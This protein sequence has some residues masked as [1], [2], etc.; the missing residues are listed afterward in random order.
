[1]TQQNG[2]FEEESPKTATWL[3]PKKRCFGKPAKVLKLENEL[4]FPEKEG[5]SYFFG[6][7]RLQDMLLFSVR[8][9]LISEFGV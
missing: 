1:M 2:G 7:P 6:K 5:I 4:W 8:H 9:R 3:V